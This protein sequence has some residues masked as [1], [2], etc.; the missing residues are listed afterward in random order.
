[1]LTVSED[2]SEYADDADDIVVVP[3]EPR[4]SVQFID[5]FEA[6][7]RQWLDL[8]AAPQGRSF[9]SL[10][11]PF[12]RLARQIP[13]EDD[14][15]LIFRPVPER[16][17][18]IWFEVVVSLDRLART[19]DLNVG[20]TL[21]ALP[22]LWAIEYPLLEEGDT[23]QHACI[24]HE[25]GHIAFEARRPGQAHSNGEQILIE[26]TEGADAVDRDPDF[27]L[28]WFTELACDL[29]AVRMLGPAFAIAL[30]EWTLSQ[31]V[32]FHEPQ[33]AGFYSHPPMP[34]RLDLLRS[35]VERYFVA[36]R[37][38]ELDVW[39]ATARAMAR[40]TQMIPRVDVPTVPELGIIERALERM[41]ERADTILGE[42]AYQ[43]TA[44]AN[45]LPAV[46][47]KLQDGMAPAE[48][49]F[50]RG[51]GKQPPPSNAWSEPIDWRSILNGGYIHYL[52]HLVE[53]S[54]EP[55]QPP[56]LL[57][58]AADRDKRRL[59]ACTHIQGSIELSELHRRMVELKE[60]LA[61]LELPELS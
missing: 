31:N 20:E 54:P 56:Q 43:P 29:L 47:G 33:S 12:R 18:G 59:T 38:H 13:N 60:Q 27:A 45:D 58:Q 46:W 26:A 48:A 7:L 16:V 36:A 53:E 25:I 37:S 23:F 34:W 15:E 49:V 1:V 28:T 52:H 8:L 41:R 32:W 42:A 57:R 35:E 17:Y 9:D 61:A 55:E 44:F 30:T 6:Q 5:E 11:E 24:A 14:F 39:K 51:E 40:W 3:L 21:D 2:D 4:L 19:L 10:A 22:R 50:S